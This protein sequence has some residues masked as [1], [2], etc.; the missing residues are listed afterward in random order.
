M[1][2]SE[3]LELAG[4][5]RGIGIA[6][7]A[8]IRA[9]PHSEAIRDRLQAAYEIEHVQASNRMTPNSW[10][11]GLETVQRWLAPPE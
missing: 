11:E 3:A 7:D 2:D 5:L 6:I 10:I 9:H 1:Q 4:Q 8:L